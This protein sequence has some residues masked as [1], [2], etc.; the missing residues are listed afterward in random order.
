[1][2]RLSIALTGAL[3][4][5]LVSVAAAQASS[6]SGVYTKVLTAYQANGRIPPCEFTS[7]QL[8]WTLNHI[9]TYGQQYY[10][11]FIGAI[12]TALTAR[13]SGACSASHPHGVAG[14]GASKDGGSGNLPGTPALPSSVTDSTS[15]GVPLLMVVLIALGAVLTA[16][17]VL[18][19]WTTTRGAERGWTTSWRHGA[20]EARYRAGGRWLEFRDRLRG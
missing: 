13:A 7:P 17:A 1:M 2:R 3:I 12:Q 5:A 8:V 14:A 6:V 11:D 9:D 4:A 18:A 10:A 19:R 20:A 15:S 16:V